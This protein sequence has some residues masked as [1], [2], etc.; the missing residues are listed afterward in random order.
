MSLSIGFF[1]S[2]VSKN[3]ET[4]NMYSMLYFFFAMFLGGL[5]FAGRSAG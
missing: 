2:S 4:F 1:L 3:V 5:F